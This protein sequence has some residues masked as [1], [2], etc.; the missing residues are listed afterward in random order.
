MIINKHICLTHTYTSV[1]MSLLHPNNFFQIILYTSNVSL[2]QIQYIT[3][4]ITAK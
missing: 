2:R 1:D 4:T 3:L